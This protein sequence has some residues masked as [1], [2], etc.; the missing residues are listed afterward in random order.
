MVRAEVGALVSAFVKP[1]AVRQRALEVAAAHRLNVSRVSPSLITACD[2]AVDK[3]VERAIAQHRR[4]SKT[5]E[6][7]M[8]AIAPTTGRRAGR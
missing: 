6:A 2:L 3:C 8:D 5:L 7:P 1:G 4:A